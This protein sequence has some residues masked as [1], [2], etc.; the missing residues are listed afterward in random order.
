MPARTLVRTN[1]PPPLE[2]AGPLPRSQGLWPVRRALPVWFLLREAALR[3]RQ[4]PSPL[5]W[6]Q[7]SISLS[8]F[9]FQSKP[10]A[11]C[12]QMDGVI[13]SPKQGAK[14]L[15][16]VKE[17]P[18]EEGKNAFLH[19]RWVSASLGS[20]LLFAANTPNVPSSPSPV[21]T[22]PRSQAQR[23]PTLCRQPSV[24]SSPRPYPSHPP[25][26]QTALPLSSHGTNS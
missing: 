15:V 25:S 2:H 20:S 8:A 9:E 13:K 5:L 21:R 4:L 23:Q 19:P 17:A 14:R 22:L 16:V 12:K 11:D 3:L 10:E 7:Y 18:R 1:P 6:L 24:T 26:H